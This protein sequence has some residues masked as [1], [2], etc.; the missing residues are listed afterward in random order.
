MMLIEISYDGQYSNGMPASTDYELLNL[1]E[2]ALLQELKDVDGYLNI[3]RETGNHL[4]TIYFSCKEFRKPSKVIDHVIE[5]YKDN[6]EIEVSLFIDK[7]WRALS[8]FT[9]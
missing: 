9:G 5:K 6:F 7:Y 8:K 2:D 1:I 4:R 3:G